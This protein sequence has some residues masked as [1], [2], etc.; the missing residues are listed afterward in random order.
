MK[1]IFLRFISLILVISFLFSCVVFAKNEQLPFK[2]VKESY[3][4]YN[5]VDYCYT[6][7]IFSGMS[8]T[9][10]RPLVTMTR[11]M[12]VCALA[13]LSGDDI[14]PFKNKPTQFRDV[15]TKAW[16]APF[17]QWA[18]E[19]GVASGVGNR[20]FGIGRSITRAEAVTML[21][22]YTKTRGLSVNVPQGN[23]FVKSY[24]DYSKVASYA[25][26]S[27]NWAIAEGIVSGMTPDTLAPKEAFNRAQAARIF[28]QYDKL[29]LPEADSYINLS[30]KP[31]TGYDIFV[32]YKTSYSYRYGPSIIVN[33]DGSI[34]S[35]YA[36]LGSQGSGSLHF[37]G[38]YKEWDH[39]TYTHITPEGEILPEK[40]V[41]QPTPDSYDFLSCCDP[42]AVYFNGYYYIG[43]TSTIHRTGLCNNVF[44]ARS[45]NPDGPYEKWNGSG[46]GG[47]A[48]PIM[49]Y[50]GSNLLWGEGEPA[51][52]ELDGTLYIYYTLKG[53][54][55]FKTM[56]ATADSTD[57]NW[58]LTL[59]KRGAALEQGNAQSGAD[60]KYVES[61]RK[62]VGIAVENS[63]QENSCIRIFESLDGI[64]YTETQK[65]YE[66]VYKYAHNIGISGDKYGHIKD[67]DNVYIAY[68]YAD[69]PQSENWGQWA[70]YMMEVDI[71]VSKNALTTDSGV[72]EF[73]QFD[74]QE[75][76][77]WRTIAVSNLP[78]HFNLNV[79][80]SSEVKIYRINSRYNRKVVED[81]SLVTFEIE[82]E[83]IV[84]IDGF[85]INAKAVGKTN[86][87]ATYDGYSITFPVNVHPED[88]DVAD[89]EIT[90][91]RAVHDV[92]TV[93]AGEHYP[94]QIRAYIS[95]NG[96][97]WGEAFN[98][99][100]S[101]AVFHRDD[102]PITYTVADPSVL[103]VDENGMVY[104]H[105]AGETTV[106]LTMGEWSYTVKVIVK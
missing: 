101:N 33:E 82:D 27:F 31:D 52:V 89:P 83:D 59:V 1:K 81:A 41:L 32:P 4:F 21:Y 7:G 76:G 44:V 20:Q 96:I 28:M 39:I 104:G 35:Y 68:A 54:H 91:F 38:G 17:V 61:Q 13:Q 55:G 78:H 106:T 6:N 48:S 56:V 60:F 67:Q 53:Q 74:T 105:K 97:K 87:T 24:S 46:W 36:G 10:F 30:L 22:N 95:L 94:H 51:F 57:E 72:N 77:E 25:R 69:A 11:E 5:A 99:T 79:D 92:Y 26:N 103:Y 37:G 98:D 15:N 86:I 58:P 42:G 40:T 63:F 49:M 75:V 66:N 88:I 14:T 34:D 18:Y 93:G 29:S 3:W 47:D 9:E 70:T 71:T 8:E 85:T 2:D 65:I 23:M 45:K 73:H 90:E 62:F 84:S 19:T 64:T 50:D 43:Y 80:T 102:Y 16:Y 12:L 100:A